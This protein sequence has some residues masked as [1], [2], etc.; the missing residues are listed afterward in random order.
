MRSWK[1]AIAAQAAQHQVVFEDG[2]A[3]RPLHR[4]EMAALDDAGHRYELVAAR[5]IEVVVMR[6][7]QPSVMGL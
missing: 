1:A 6:A 5:A 2:G 7:D 3:G 4:G